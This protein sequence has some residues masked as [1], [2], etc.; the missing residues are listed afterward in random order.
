MFEFEKEFAGLLREFHRS[1]A[2]E[3]LV[4][5]GSWCLPVY[6]E[7]YP[8]ARFPFTTSD[9]DFSVQRPRA[10]KSGPGIPLHELLIQLGYIAKAGILSKAE[11]YIPAPDAEGTS[12]SIEFLCEPGRDVV[13][14]LR[15]PGLG[16]VVSSRYHRS[17]RAR[18]ANSK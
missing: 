1:G 10:F 15:L 18:I 9:I 17:E 5:I 2:L 14:P 7:H 8:I 6:R 12:L 3:H 11:K 13:D 4:L 16:I